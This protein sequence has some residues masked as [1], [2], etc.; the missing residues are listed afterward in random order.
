MFFKSVFVFLC[1]CIWC[2]VET[3]LERS[4]NITTHPEDTEIEKLQ[5]FDKLNRSAHLNVSPFYVIDVCLYY[6]KYVN[7]VLLLSLLSILYLYYK[8]FTSNI[9]CVS[10]LS[11]IL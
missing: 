1:S 4:R 5:I 11:S 9:V 3:S 8:N 2:Y 6:R 7:V 10:H